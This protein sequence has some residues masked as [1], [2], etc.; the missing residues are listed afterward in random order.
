MVWFFAR[1]AELL[2]IEATHD[3]SGAFILTLYRADGQKQRETFTSEAACH[4]RLEQMEQQLRA[5]S[6]TLRM[7]CPLRTT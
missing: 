1:E 5:D 6:W 3:A 7:V 2:R 4:L